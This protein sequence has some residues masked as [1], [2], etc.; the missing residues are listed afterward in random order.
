MQREPIADSE[1]QLRRGRRF[2][3]SCQIVQ[4]CALVAAGMASFYGA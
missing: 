1:R 3:T 2:W 4:L